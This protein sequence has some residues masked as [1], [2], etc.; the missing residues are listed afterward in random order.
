MKT[1]ETY[2][3]MTLGYIRGSYQYLTKLHLASIE[4]EVLNIHVLNCNI[5]DLFLYEQKIGLVL[6][7]LAVDPHRQNTTFILDFY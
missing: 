4:T 2:T 5:L 6:Y 3:S 7:L 1:Y